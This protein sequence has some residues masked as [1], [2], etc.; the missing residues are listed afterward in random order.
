MATKGR[1]CATLY[2]GTRWL[3]TRLPHFGPVSA[4]VPVATNYIPLY[5]KSSASPIPPNGNQLLSNLKSSASQG[6]SPARD[7]LTQTK[8]AQAPG[9]GS[10][11]QYPGCR[12]LKMVDSVCR[13]YSP[14]SSRH[15]YKSWACAGREVLVTSGPAGGEGGRYGLLGL[16][17]SSTS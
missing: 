9:S 1:L 6:V 13:E 11:L 2:T 3:L 14:L 4:Y 15:Q 16:W 8:Y 7:D 10:H 12:Y 5:P 17:S